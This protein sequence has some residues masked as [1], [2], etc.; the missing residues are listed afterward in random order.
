MASLQVGDA[1]SIDQFLS[2]K[3]V[4]GLPQALARFHESEVITGNILRSK[5][6]ARH[7]TT[8][9]KTRPIVCAN[10]VAIFTSSM[11]A[12]HRAYLDTFFV[13]TRV[14]I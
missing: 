11:M 7:M 6:Q 5:E 12:R 13:P 4:D 1:V 2:S 10:F 9:I 8:K 14:S 3:Y